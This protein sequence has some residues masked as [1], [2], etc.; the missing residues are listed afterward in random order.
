MSHGF[1]RRT[2]RLGRGDPVFVLGAAHAWRA[3]DATDNGVITTTLPPFIGGLTLVPNGAG[4]PIKAAS[5]G[6]R[7]AV[8]VP[9]NGVLGNGGYGAAMAISAGFS[10]LTI[11]RATGSNGS[12]HAMNVGAS[13]NTGNSAGFS[14]AT[15]FSQKILS[16]SLRAQ[17]FPGDCIMVSVF[18]ATGRTH[19]CNALTPVSAAQAGALAGDNFMIGAAAAGTFV[20]NGQ[21]ERTAV[22]LR[23]L[24]QADVAWALRFYGAMFGVSI[25]P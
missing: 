9:F 12:T 22:F 24:A 16:A 13:P 7:G 5:A 23:A 21:W 18:D 1:E 25:A 8:T 10:V 20:L 14:G 4:H 11:V 2:G 17:S 6:L 3:S 15:S 19:Y